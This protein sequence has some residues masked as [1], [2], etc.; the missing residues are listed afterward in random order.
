MCGEASQL[1]QRDDERKLVIEVL[2]R[3]PSAEG[4][5]L[6]V[7]YL[8]SAELKSEASSTAVTIAEKVLPKKPAAVADAMQQVLDSGDGDV[9]KRAQALLDQARKSAGKK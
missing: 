1:C 5:A 8:R 4:L 6:V 3:N 2:R 9:A 7:T